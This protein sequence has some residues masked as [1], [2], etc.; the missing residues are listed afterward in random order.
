MISIK[1]NVNSIEEFNYL[2]DAVG[3]G[4]YDEK[5]SEKALA[6]T[7]H[8]VSVYDD[9]KI[10]GYGRIIGDGICFLLHHHS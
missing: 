9:D 5:V 10:I 2:Y 3:W 7:M 1:E 6:N 8:S 4:S